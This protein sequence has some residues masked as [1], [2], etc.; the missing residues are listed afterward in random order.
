MDVFGIIGNPVGHS[1][2]PVMHEAAFTEL[3]INAR[4]V[5]F[6]PE[7]EALEEAITGAAALRITG[8]NVTI[9]FKQAVLDFVRTDELATQIG[10]VNTIDFSTDPPTGYNTDA[11]G[12]KRSLEHHGVEITGKSAVLVG[13][14]GAGRAIAHM[15][16]EEGA[17]VRIVNRTES[18]ALELADAVNGSGYGLTDI[19]EL[20]PDADLLINATSVGM[21]EDVSPVHA[22]ALHAGLV[23][24]DA[25]YQP[26]RTRL[27]RDAEAA[28]A[29]TIDGAWMLL[30][31]GVEAFERWT[32]RS[33]PIE[34]M[35][36]ALRR[37]L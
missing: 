36:Q 11:T 8:L 9:P 30:F 25:V 17:N 1:R 34:T 10:A 28:G 24:M 29:T 35:N 27:L 15:L 2:S 4:Y 22:D 32:G 31:Q 6:E 16:A 20:L 26:L 12:A 3:G 7:P 23:V 13:A 19:T 14:G 21:E 5:I 18:R 37:S 33:A